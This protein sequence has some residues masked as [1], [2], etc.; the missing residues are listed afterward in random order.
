[1]R[2]AYLAS[3][4]GFSHELSGYLE[5]VK[6]RLREVG[7]E[8]TDPWEQS[9][10]AELEAARHV[11]GHDARHRML[12]DLAGVIGSANERLIREADILFAVLDGA[13]VDSGTA[14]EVGFAA[15]LGKVC[16]GLRTDW[17][18]SGDLPGLPLNLQVLH[19]IE[20]SGGSLF[21]RIEDIMIEQTSGDS[22]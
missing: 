10:A 18:N 13:E 6:A 22:L 17:R 4:L 16:Y 12:R 9:Y 5:R 2:K 15:G 19:F 7:L 3:P 21:R 1:M 14:S 8:V 20:W 11:T